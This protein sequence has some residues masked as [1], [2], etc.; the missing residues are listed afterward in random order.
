MLANE[1]LYSL[2]EYPIDSSYELSSYP[3]DDDKPQKE[4]KLE[5][6]TFTYPTTMISRSAATKATI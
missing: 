4:E 5:E 6:K 3:T 2:K 1:N